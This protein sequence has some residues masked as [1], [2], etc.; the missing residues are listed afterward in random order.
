MKHSGTDPDEESICKAPIHGIGK[1]M[2]LRRL[3]INPS[4]YAED[5]D[6]DN[7][8]LEHE[9]NEGDEDDESCEEDDDGE[10]EEPEPIFGL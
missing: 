6:E 5:S 3:I 2:T 7:E 1:S 10:V 9:S 8:E 4:C